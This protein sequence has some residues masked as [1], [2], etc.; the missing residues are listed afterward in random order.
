VIYDGLQVV[1][2]S[3]GIAGAYCAKLLTDLGADV[4]HIEPDDGDPLRM[5]SPSA[6]CGADG[7]PDGALFRYLRTSQRSVV[8][9]DPRAWVAAA[10][11]VIESSRPGVAEDDGLIGVAPVTVSLSAFGRGGPDTGLSLPEEILQARSGSLANH[12]HMD[13]PPLTVGGRL[14]E[15]ATGA[16]AALGAATAWRRYRLTGEHDHVDVSMF[17]AMHLTLVTTPTLMARFPGGRK[18][19]FRFVMIPGNEPSRDGFVGITTVTRQQW[20]AFLRVMGR[21]DLVADDGIATFIGRFARATEVNGLIHEWTTARSAEEIVELCTAAR[22]PAA[23]VGNGATLPRVPQLVARRAIVT[24]PGASFVRPRAPF[25]FSA[26]PDRELTPAPRLGE[27]SGTEPPPPQQQHLFGVAGRGIDPVLRRRTG[28]RPLAGVR[29]LDFT[30]FWAGPFATA[31]MVAMG[32][33]VMKVE[34]V[35]RPDGIRFSAAVNPKDD[36]DHYEKSALFHACNLGKRSI[37]LDLGHPEGQE[38]ARRLI[39]RVDVVAEN[40]TPPVMDGFGLS[41]DEVAAIKPDVVMLRLPAFGLDGPWRDRPGFAQTMEQLT[42]MAWLTGYQGGPPIIPGGFVDPL[43]GTHAALAVVAA[44]EHR[45]RTGEG[46]LVEMPMIEVAAAVTGE[47]IVEH[48]AY[49]ALLGRRGEHGV[50]ACDGDDAWVAVDERDD[51]LPPHERARWCASRSA[52]TAARE[53]MA[54]GISAAAVVPGYATLDDPQL[55]ARGFFQRIEHPA[56][57]VQEYP[58]FPVRFASRAGGDWW[59]GPAPRLGEHTAE[60]LRRELGLSD[61]DL[62]GLAAEQ[63]IGTRPVSTP[64]PGPPPSGSGGT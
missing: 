33:E 34:S 25:R 28:E 42:G 55:R 37:T 38:L 26:V 18:H 41:Y 49:Q 56:V 47:Q 3:T 63:V 16:F 11:V 51:P 45:D 4:V 50:Y 21:D 19:G 58:G 2:L 13:R 9:P 36:P 29:V 57:G 15:Y 1:D 60:V 30:A 48:S 20:Y 44:L 62:E 6:S 12:G 8:A 46:Q 54:D 7:D 22:V 32:A 5:F 10:D 17:E 64:S 59:P 31:W 14:G 39:A 52:E 27:H 35:Q 40:F 24:Q 53:L 61:A 43:V 23:V